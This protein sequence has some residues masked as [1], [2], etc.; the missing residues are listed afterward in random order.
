MF[1]TK[2]VVIDSVK[3]GATKLGAGRGRP[4]FGLGRGGQTY[5]VGRGVGGNMVKNNQMKAEVRAAV[6]EYL[7][8]LIAERSAPG[9]GHK[10]AVSSHDLMVATNNVGYH[11][12]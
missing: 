9:Q 10:M 12:K 3:C 7:S 1:Q 6:K 4:A 5:P 11:G 8:G 2:P